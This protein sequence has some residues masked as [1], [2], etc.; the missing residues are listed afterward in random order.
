MDATL[1]MSDAFWA[2]ERPVA[3][4]AAGAVRPDLSSCP[5]HV[6]FQ[7]SGSTAAPKWV[8]LSRRGLMLS[9]TVVNHHLGV[10]AS[11]CWGLLLPLHH[12]GGFG[13]VARA[14]A[15]GCR[16]VHGAGRWQAPEAAA[17]LRRERVT[18]VSMVPTQ[19]VDLV[20]AAIR[21]PDGLQ[22]VV[23]GG[24]HLPVELGRQARALGWPV[25]A[26]YGMTEAATQ[27]ATQGLEA[28][29]EPYRP[30]P[31]PVLP[32]WRVQ[33]DDEGRLLIAGESLF[34]GLLTAGHGGWE[35]EA[36]GGEWFRT[37][38]RVELADDQLSPLGRVD[39]QVKVL[40][41]LVDLEA[42]ERQLVQL[43]ARALAS[44]S[45]VVVAL[46]DERAEHRLVPVGDGRLDPELLSRVLASYAAMA[47]GYAR[48]EPPLLLDDFPRSPLGKP[49]RAECLEKCRVRSAE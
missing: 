42:I 23:V 48:L 6:F 14:R 11:S 25:L 44:D 41:E 37:R 26:S 10:D 3:M 19:V 8:G 4:A 9:A 20:R 28:L 47:P 34:S 29:A 45:L 30:S 33:V 39:L 31:M 7:T 32:H 27:I 16:V 12:V 38:D 15:A 24:G 35:F 17:W 13:V 36:R 22:A 5:G 2:D 40:G 49:M 1:L 21:G 46:P 18:H 43:S